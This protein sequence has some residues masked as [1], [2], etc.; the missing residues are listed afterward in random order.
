MQWRRKKKFIDPKFQI[1]FAMWLLVHS[2][3][4]FLLILFVMFIT[5]MADWFNPGLDYRAVMTDFFA[6]LAAKWPLLILITALTLLMGNFF[7]HRIVGPEFRFKQVLKSLTEKELNVFLKLRKWDYHKGL[8]KSFKEFVAAH[9]ESISTLK[10]GIDEASGALEKQDSQK[11]KESLT[12]L[13]DHI[14]KYK[15]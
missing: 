8:E 15:L 14:D 4:F 12:K 6:L 5:P 3:I 7:S 2:L 9:K 10:S 13:K 1:S 11:L